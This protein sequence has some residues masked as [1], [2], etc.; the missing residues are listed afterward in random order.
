[1]AEMNYPAAW[2]NYLYDFHVTRDYFE[3]HEHLEEYW[4]AM[5]QADSSLVAFIQL[6][7]GCYHARRNNRI[8]AR[9]MWEGASSYLEAEQ[10]SDFG[11]DIHALKEQLLLW[12]DSLN[13]MEPF[14]DIEL[15][16]TDFALRTHIIDLANKK[17]RTFGGQS[18]QNDAELVERHQRRDRSEIIDARNQS[19]TRKRGIPIDDKL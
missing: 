4:K 7:V 12:I 19:L 3:C 16:F 18:N 10:V 9:K 15:P 13:R 8:G 6:A 14:S 17:G 2:I 1:M 5:G 11:I